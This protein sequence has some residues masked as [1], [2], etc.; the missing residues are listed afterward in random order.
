MEAEFLVGNPAAITGRRCGQGTKRRVQLCS[1]RWVGQTLELPVGEG[2]ASFADSFARP[3]RE[4]N[5]N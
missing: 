1:D 5:L 4:L 3:D 2:E